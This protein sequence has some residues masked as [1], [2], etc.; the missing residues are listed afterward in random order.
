VVVAVAAAAL[1]QWEM[2]L[3]DTYSDDIGQ[4]AGRPASWAGKL[5]GWLT[6]LRARQLTR[7]TTSHGIVRKNPRPAPLK[8]DVS[9]LFSLAFESMQVSKCTS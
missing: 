3:R 4:L 8:A 9:L 7:F 2:R 5:A 6:R 1:R